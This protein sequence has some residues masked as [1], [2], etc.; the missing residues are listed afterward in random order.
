MILRKIKLFLYIALNKE[1]IKKAISIAL[2]VG[3]ILNLINQGDDIIS[4]NFNDIN[5]LKFFLTFTVPFCVSMYTATSM[6]L[7]FHVGEKSSLNTHLQCKSC[8]H[9]IYIKENQT[10]PFCEICNEKTKWK[11]SS[12]KE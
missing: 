2:V 12:K 3:I 9:I 5:Y 4:L 6:K 11:V 10:I 1:L 7:K 8:K